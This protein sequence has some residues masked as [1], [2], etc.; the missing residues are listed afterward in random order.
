[1]ILLVK[2]NNFD[3]NILFDCDIRIFTILVTCSNVFILVYE[4]TDIVLIFDIVAMIMYFCAI[5]AV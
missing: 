2:L 1:V 5:V 3:I 4:L